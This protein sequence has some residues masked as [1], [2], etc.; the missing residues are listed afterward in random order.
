MIS[1]V[2]I[3]CSFEDTTNFTCILVL[4][5]LSRKNLVEFK[6]CGNLE[7]GWAGFVD[8]LFYMLHSDK[9]G[10]PEGWNCGHMTPQANSPV[11]QW[12]HGPVDWNYVLHG[13]APMDW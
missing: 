12:L 3:T 9:T 13:C 7:I 10:G 4:Y 8:T 6:K 5:G 2:S 11:D 1:R